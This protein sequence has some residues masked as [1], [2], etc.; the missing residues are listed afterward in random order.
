MI[1]ITH[2]HRERDKRSVRIWIWILLLLC[3]CRV[4]RSRI[5]NYY[6]NIDIDT[7]RRQRRERDGSGKWVQERFNG[8]HGNGFRSNVCTSLD[9]ACMSASQLCITH[10]LDGAC[11][12]WPHWN[13]PHV[14]IWLRS[15]FFSFCQ[16][17]FFFLLRFVLYI[18]T[19][20]C[21]PIHIISLA[22][23]A[24]AVRWQASVPKLCA[25][26]SQMK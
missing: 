9:P 8:W 25:R 6:R 13:M 17:S 2:S 7:L 20:A 19:V 23:N 18:S 3:C 12:I 15:F 24:L 5:K 10:C 16:S 14:S 4:E 22:L 1:R 26:S 11:V 21:Y